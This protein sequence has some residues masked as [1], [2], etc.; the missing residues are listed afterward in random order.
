[1]EK[2]VFATREAPG[3]S[4]EEVNGYHLKSRLDPSTSQSHSPTSHTALREIRETRSSSPVL[5]F[6]VFFTMLTSPLA[7]VKQQYLSEHLHKYGVQFL[8][9]DSNLP[10]ESQS[11]TGRSDRALVGNV[12]S[13]FPLS[14]SSA[15]MP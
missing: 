2:V 9:V 13:R 10:T 15:T 3:E 14:R 11:I 5:G 7:S 6:S 4:E 8:T 1:M 12:I